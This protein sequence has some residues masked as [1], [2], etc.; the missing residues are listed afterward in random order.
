MHRIVRNANGTE[1]AFP[2]FCGRPRSGAK[3]PGFVLYRFRLVQVALEIKRR[4]MRGILN[5]NT[6][7]TFLHLI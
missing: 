6:V 4:L 2:N 5:R 1:L 7:A 3:Y